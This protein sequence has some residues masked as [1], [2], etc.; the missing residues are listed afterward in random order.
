LDFAFEVRETDL[1]GR[2]GHLKVGGKV[3]E[4][5][6]LFPVIHPV[7]QL[8][9]PRTLESMGFH[10]LMTNSYIIHSRR[11]DEALE[12]GIHRMLDFDGVF[13]TDSGGYQV[14]EYGNL[15]VDYAE[16]AGF[17]ADL[18]PE[19][20]V[21]LD[22]PTGLS[23]S[24]SYA[25]GTMEYSLE[26]AILTLKEFGERGTVWLG[27]V[28]GG[29]FHGLL[30]K[31]AGSLIEAGFLY[32]ALGSPV[33][34]MQ[35]YRFSELVG[36]IAATRRA[37]P[38]AT[39]LHLFGAGHPLTMAISVALGCDT[40][41]SASY[42]LFAREGRYMTERGVIRMDSMKYL[43]CSCSVCS[44]TTMKELLELDHFERTSALAMHN[45]YVLKK[46]I[47]ACKEAISEGRLWDL[48]CEKGAAHPRLHEAVSELAKSKEILMEG[49]H[50]PKE[51][52]LFVRDELDFSRPEILRAKERLERLRFR[53]TKTAVLLCGGSAQQ[54]G[55]TKPGRKAP[56]GLDTYR[57]HPVFGPYPVEL[58]FAY[59]FGQTVVDVDQIKKVTPTQ[60]VKR[61]R[62]M[63]YGRVIVRGRTVEAEGVRISKS[64][65]TRRGL[66]PSVP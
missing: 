10:G 21:T 32:L 43:P 34:V 63:G 36:M 11:K 16:V 20:A 23:K 60:A 3:L 22:R 59:P 65:R 31:S 37:M 33:Q 64:K 58:E 46:E 14:L 49:T 7:Q 38:Y 29:L 1:F 61:L 17:Q 50:F 35:N 39:P 56:R 30:R 66:S 51:K 5:P 24:K 62:S 26:N 19:F 57:L 6:Y 54:F 52:G 8:V 2:I 40:F 15:D 13:M 12:K 44:R 4:T 18:G 42:I 28:Q 47:E 41:D 9:S 45:L 55:K 53:N 48:I 25:K 27:P